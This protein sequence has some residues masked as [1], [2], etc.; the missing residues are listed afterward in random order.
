MLLLGQKGPESFFLLPGKEG[1]PKQFLPLVPSVPILSLRGR[2]A[3]EAIPSSKAEEGCVANACV[4][5]RIVWDCFASLAM[6]GWCKGAV[7]CLVGT[8]GALS[9]CRVGR[10]MHTYIYE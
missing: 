9:R 3:A 7:D 8:F 4:Q 5:C 10:I 2:K 1:K 6:T